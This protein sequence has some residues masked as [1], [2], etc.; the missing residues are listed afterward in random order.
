MEPPRKRTCICPCPACNGKERDLR[1]VQRHTSIFNASN[2]ITNQDSSSHLTSSSHLS[3]NPHGSSSHPSNDP[4]GSSSNPSDN[5]HGSSSNPSDNPHGSS[6]H[7]SDDPHS[8][9]SHPSDDPHGSS[10]YPSNDPYG[11]SSSP[12][13][14]PHTLDPNSG[15]NDSTIDFV[16]HE[17][18]IKLTHGSSRGE[19]EEHLKNASRLISADKR[20]QTSWS[21]V[22]ALMKKLGYQ[23]PRHYKVCVNELHSLL[24]SI[25]KHPRC[26]ICQT[27]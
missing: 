17:V 26:P 13:D 22:V 9:S 19:L 15:V 27:P 11:R 1:T 5:P 10:S 2:L 16:L 14:N 12:S 4:H 18:F 3:D 7:P 20:I 6:L 25:S 21:E 24:E 8:S 23:P